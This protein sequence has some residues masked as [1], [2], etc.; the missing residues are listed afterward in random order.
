MREGDETGQIRKIATASLSECFETA[1]YKI[2]EAI[3]R[4]ANSASW[5]P[6]APE[7]S[8]PGNTLNLRQMIIDQLGHL[9]HRD[10]FLAT[11]NR[12]QLVVGIDIAP[13]F[14]VL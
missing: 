12:L 9:E 13:V 1:I 2:R 5:P 6:A 11:E 7:R 14:A 10:L 4:Q 8:Q 3:Y